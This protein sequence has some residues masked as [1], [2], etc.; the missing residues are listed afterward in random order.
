VNNPGHFSYFRGASNDAAGII[1]GPYLYTFNRW[2]LAF[3]ADLGVDAV[4]TPLENNR[5]NLERT[6]SPGRRGFALITLFARPALFRIRADM[7]AISGMEEFSGGRGEEFRLLAG[8]EGSQ[9]IP[10]T[11]FSI[12]DKRPF[13]ETS[14]FHRFILDLSGPPLKKKDYRALMTAYQSAAPIPGISRFNWKDG[15]FH[16]DA[17]EGKN[18]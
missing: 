11:P 18:S 2:S 3:T 4:I 12:V 17:G 15:F 16:D 1:A 14:G 5:Q 10:E 9:V 7:R 13:L 6:V 8:R